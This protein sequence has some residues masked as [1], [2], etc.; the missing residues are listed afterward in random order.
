MKMYKQKQEL[1]REIERHMKKN[2]DQLKYFSNQIN[3][4]KGVAAKP[5]TRIQRPCCKS[6]N[7]V[8]EEK[9]FHKSSIKQPKCLM[10]NK[11]EIVNVMNITKYKCIKHLQ[12]GCNN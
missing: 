12:I 3:N 2:G 6:Q 8:G 7:I 10:R 1:Q 5:F 9:T 11:V 4:L